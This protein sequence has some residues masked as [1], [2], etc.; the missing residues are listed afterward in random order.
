MEYI[1]T[2]A[3]PKQP[4]DAKPLTVRVYTLKGHKDQ[5]R[6]ALDVCARTLEF[7][8]EYFDIAYPL[9]KVGAKKLTVVMAEY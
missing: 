6:F 9:P 1:E 3:S 5:G 8:S 4:S 7:F 2:Q